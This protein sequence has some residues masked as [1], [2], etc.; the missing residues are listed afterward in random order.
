[1]SSSHVRK[2]AVATKT[3]TVVSTKAKVVALVVGFMALGL[4]AYGFGFIPDLNKEPVLS[5]EQC[6]SSCEQVLQECANSPKADI[7]VC[8]ATY[9]SCASNCP[10]TVAENTPPQIEQPPQDQTPPPPVSAEQCQSDCGQAFQACSAS[11]KMDISVCKAAYQTCITNCP[12]AATVENVSPPAQL[13]P[14]AADNPA[15]KNIPPPDETTGVTGDAGP[16]ADEINIPSTTPPTEVV[17]DCHGASTPRVD[18]SATYLI[19][20]RPMF[21][22]TLS[23]FI[24]A[25][26]ARGEVVQ[27]LLVDDLA[28]L[29]E[30]RDVQE[31]IR[32]YL[33]QIHMASSV[34][35]V[36]IVGAPLRSASHEARDLAL[37][38]S[39]LTQPWEIPMRYVKGLATVE[40]IP[41]DQYY[42]SLNDSWNIGLDD[43]GPTRDV[44][45][46]GWQKT[47]DFNFAFTVGRVPVRS[48]T[49]LAHWVDKTLHWRVPTAFKESKFVTALCGSRQPD[50]LDEWESL[51]THV[52]LSHV[53]QTDAGGEIPSYANR[54]LPDLVSSY[55]HGMVTEIVRGESPT[56]YTMTVTSMGFTKPPIMFVHGCEVAGVDYP[57][58]SLAENYIARPDGVVA[59][60][61]STRSHWDIPFLF[62]EAVFNNDHLFL[63]EALYHA[64]TQKIMDEHL[65]LKEIDNL[66]MFSLY[67][68]PG[69]QVVEPAIHIQSATSVVHVPGITYHES[70]SLPVSVR[71]S[72][73]RAFTGGLHQYFDP[74]RMEE[75]T[76]LEDITLPAHGSTS[77]I[78]RGFSP[79]LLSIAPRVDH[80]LPTQFGTIQFSS[81]R[82]GACDTSHMTCIANRITVVPPV[83]LS[84]ARLGSREGVVDDFYTIIGKKAEVKMMSSSLGSVP[85]TFV[86]TLYPA[87][88]MSPMPGY[89]S[90]SRRT[91]TEVARMRVDRPERNGVYEFSF[92]RTPTST[93]RVRTYTGPDW[94][95]QP[96]FKAEAFDDA[97]N[98][99]GWCWYNGLEPDIEGVYTGP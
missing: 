86:L 82:S 6:R 33:R 89:D 28:C 95:Y 47:F 54:E 9:E 76:T 4:A 66:F 56:G 96:L 43:L 71:S 51:T 39:T 24:A 74:Y 7:S 10:A 41:T 91:G 36:L 52:V 21:V 85:L 1:M 55:S 34:R 70:F 83:Y 97:G 17:Y 16:T 80:D 26:E 57:E 25:K 72:I 13:E 23:P 64:K 69:L 68:D 99:Q 81:P 31:K 53:C 12:V 40:P 49:D 75:P 8:K 73:D 67:G 44:A 63:G 65:T 62:Q 88:Y 30:G 90:L 78:L 32:F 58:A 42:A 22:E 35:N 94:Y 14:P 84:C 11:P 3:K 5:A 92:D 87:V 93:H 45:V 61:G 46:H 19:L 38:G 48:A 15:P 98:R 27:T 37:I 59:F 2:I 20:T 79:P 77:A 29:G 60:I 18:P 50:P